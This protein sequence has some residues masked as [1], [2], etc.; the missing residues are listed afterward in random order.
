MKN[1]TP[2]L[3]AQWASRQEEKKPQGRAGHLS[4]EE[5][6]VIRLAYLES[7]GTETYIE[8]GRRFSVNRETV[9]ACLKGPDF[10]KLR[11][12]V[13]SEARTIAIQRLMAAVVPAADAW[14]R[15]IDEAADKGDH[16]PA[17]ELLLHTR[18]IE[19]LD[20][21]Q[22]AGVTVIIGGPVDVQVNAGI[23]TADDE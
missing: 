19:P 23:T 8:L 22:G 13:E 3:I 11:A 16:K 1:Q 4:H 10:D 5:K 9:S 20:D 12:A 18:T 6:T 15:A 21:A 14:V 2:E 7:G 17:K